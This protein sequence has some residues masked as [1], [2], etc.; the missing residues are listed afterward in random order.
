MILKFYETS[1]INLEKVSI[2]LFHGKNEGAKQDEISRILSSNKDRVFSKYDEKQVLENENNFYENLFSGSLFENKKVICISRASNKIYKIIENLNQKNLNDLVIIIDS[3]NLDKKS[4]L[5][6]LIEKSEKCVSIAF[7]PDTDDTLFKIAYNF[8]KEDNLQLSR[9]NLN[10]VINQCNG[11]RGILKSELNKIKMF[12][13]NRKV[14]KSEDII[15]LTNLI[16]DHSISELIDNCLAK[17][18]HKT[19]SI[20]NENNITAEEC[21]IIIRT[22]LNRAKRLSNLSREFEKNKDLN[23]TILNSKPPIFWKE[24]EIVKQQLINWKKSQINKLIVEAN[25]MEFQIKKNYNN[26]VNITSNFIL[27]KLNTSN[28]NF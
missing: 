15:K 25:N 2:I 5:R 8:L 1:K 23:K 24:K 14:I 9:E 4:K 22:F 20:L 3:E 16:E 19:L 13:I 17:N 26:A 28:N 21:I 7:F 10:L 27:E 6:S 11:D 12:M 18:K